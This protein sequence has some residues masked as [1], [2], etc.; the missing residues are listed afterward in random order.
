[1]T[2]CVQKHT[3]V[4]L[5]KR[6]LMI[7]NREYLFVFF[8]FFFSFLRFGIKSTVSC[9]SMYMLLSDECQITY[10]GLK[11]PF[12]WNRKENVSKMSRIKLKYNFMNRG[13]M[14]RINLT[15]QD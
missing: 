7:E 14:S 8:N 1:M 4:M 13:E 3:L 11:M 5:N 9:S 12:Q 2:C 15:F 6:L 10:M